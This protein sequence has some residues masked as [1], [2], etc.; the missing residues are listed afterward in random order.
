MI[1]TDHFQRWMSGFN[2]YKVNSIFMPALLLSSILLLP[3]PVQAQTYE[4]LH[5]FTGAPDGCKP[6][7]DLLRDGAGNLYGTTANCGSSNGVVFKVSATGQEKILYRFTG[8]ADGGVP[9]AGLIRDKAG[10]FYGTAYSGGA[11]GEGVV[12]ELSKGK[13]TVLHSFSGSDGSHPAASLIRDAAGNFY[14]TTFYGGTASCGCGTVFKID[15]V[16]VETVLYSFTGGADGKFPAGRLLLDSMGNLYGTASE[17]GNVNCGRFGMY[18][19]G[20]VFKVNSGGTENVLYSF[21]GGADGGQPLAGLIRDSAG[22]F[23]GT[24]FSAGDLSRNCALNN[25]CG[26]VFEL[27]KSGQETV[28]YTFTNGTDGAN[29]TADLVR[30]SAG[31]LYGTTKLGG[32][33]YG[34]VF[35]VQGGSEAALYTFQGNND[36]AG[37][38][39][40]LIRDSSGNLY[41]TTSFGGSTTEGVVFKRTP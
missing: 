15:T 28:L 36:G 10:N 23:Y 40:G 9:E 39:A 7:G 32:A 41:G 16:G 33:G 8:K 6:Q 24:T 30:D 19:C 22:N 3:R 26:V 38:L 4:V 34:L 31:N 20:V 18:G 1:T 14:G 12:F 17:G 25:G 21:T 11:S 27:S 37:P 13:E 29:P 5:S 2:G 35:E